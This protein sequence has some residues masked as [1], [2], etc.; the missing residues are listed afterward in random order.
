MNGELYTHEY[1]CQGE[2][3]KWKLEGRSETATIFITIIHD[4]GEIFEISIFT[5]V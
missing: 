5:K 2:A 1:M 3:I 4:F